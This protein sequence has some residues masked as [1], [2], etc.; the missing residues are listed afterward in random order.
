METT[1]G[2]MTN[3]GLFTIVC[4]TVAI[5][6]TKQGVVAVPVSVNCTCPFEISVGPGS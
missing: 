3:V 4:V 2:A 1:V 5:E 6:L